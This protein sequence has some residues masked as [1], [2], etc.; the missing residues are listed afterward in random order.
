MRMDKTI[1]IMSKGKVSDSMGGWLPSQEIEVASIDAF[2]T[3]VQASTLLKEYGIISTKAF[4][5]ITFDDVPLKDESGNKTYFKLEDGSE[6][7]IT[8]LN[9]YGKEKILLVELI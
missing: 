6:Y 9:D 7:K 1:T 4:K 5:V 3:P 2:I 8:Q